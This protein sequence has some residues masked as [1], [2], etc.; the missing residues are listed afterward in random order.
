[1]EISLKT[2]IKYRS[3]HVSLSNKYFYSSYFLLLRCFRLKIKLKKFIVNVLLFLPKAFE[4]T[5][6]FSEIS[7]TNCNIFLCWYCKAYF[8]NVAGCN[9]M[10][11]FIKWCTYTR[12]DGQWGMGRK[13]ERKKD[14]PFDK[15]RLFVFISTFYM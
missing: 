11:Q 12:A 15:T 5:H 6:N 4:K 13:N 8:V 10:S 1:M 7:I 14:T 2:M 3:A 9:H